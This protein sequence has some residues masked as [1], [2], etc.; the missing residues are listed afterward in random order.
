MGRGTRRGETHRTVQES[1][2]KGGGHLVE[3]AGCGF[4]THGVV[5]HDPTAER[6]VADEE[7]GVHADRAFEARKPLGKGRPAPL[8]ARPQGRKWHAL[9]IGHHPEEVLSVGHARR[10]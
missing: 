6:R 8:H 9:D 1:L 5:A 7:S 3:L 4:V 10:C 2:V